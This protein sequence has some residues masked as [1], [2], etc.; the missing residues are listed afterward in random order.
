MESTHLT[1][2]APDAVEAE[3]AE[4]APRQRVRIL[5]EKGESIKFISHQD[6][7]RLWERTVR[8][9]DLPLLY[10]QGFNPQPHIQFASPL[11]VG[12]TG[13]QEPVD[14]IFS[15]P[16]PLEELRRRIEAKLPPGVRLHHI[17]EVPLKTQALQSLL[18][19]ADYTILIFAEPGEIP[20]AQLQERI[21]AFLA[22]KEV[23][24]ERQ[25]KGKTYLYNLRPLVLELTYQGYVP[26]REEHRIF[27]RVQQ[28]AGATGRPDEVVA[29]MGFE[30]FART[31]RRERLYFEHIPEDAALFARYPVVAQEEI[32]ARPSEPG[33]GRRRRPSQKQKPQRRPAGRSINERAADEFI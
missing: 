28:R 13:V 31:L 23:W 15:P 24:R 29:A 11:G 1:T 9:A 3:Q 2:S 18:I 32:M 5:F 19:G 6:V 33:R 7:F 14:M 26:E 27:L 17:E 4:E 21:E 20:E 12:I 16:V 30:A 10:K 8:R 22:Q 25:R